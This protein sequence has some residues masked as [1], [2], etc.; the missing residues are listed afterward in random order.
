MASDD[1]SRRVLVSVVDALRTHA[2]VHGLKPQPRR[3]IVCG[4]R[5]Y[6]DRQRIREVL[7]EYMPPAPFDE[8]TIV[9]GAAR[10]ADLTAADVALREGFWV[11]AH[12]ARWKRDGKAAGPLRNEEM[13]R[14][15]AD[16]CI[17]FP[18]GAGTED[19][20]R[21][22]INHGIPVRRVGDRD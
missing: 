10:G 12:P 11:E 15:G 20:I 2:V 6:T 7:D 5:G 17:A 3:I 21:R 19:M 8:P 13:A 1:V 14:L 18:G 16:L 22:C 9:H 4:G